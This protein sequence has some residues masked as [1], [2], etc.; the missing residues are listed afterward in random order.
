MAF[1]LR[2]RLSPA[3]LGLLKGLKDVRIWTRL[4]KFF[5]WGASSVVILVPE[6]VGRLGNNLVQLRN[7]IGLAMEVGAA[8]V[9]L[10]EDFTVSKTSVFP[11]RV[12]LDQESDGLSRPSGD[13]I[14][15]RAPVVI[16]ADWY[17]L[18]SEMPLSHTRLVEAQEMVLAAISSALGYVN[19]LE[20]SEKCVIHYRT[21]DV[22][23]SSPHKRYGPPPH[24]YYLALM[25]TWEVEE[26]TL[27]CEN[28]RETMVASLVEQLEAARVAV[29]VTNGCLEEDVFHILSCTH[30]ASSQGTFSVAL[31]S[32]NPFLR[33]FGYFETSHG[34][35]YWYPLSASCSNWVVRDNS[36]YF[37]EQ[38]Q[39]AN[40]TGSKHQTDLVETYPI[41]QLS[42]T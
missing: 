33:H 19:R 29:S 41:T 31:G 5:P 15:L 16:E 3:I 9:W 8:S 37:S 34:H 27:V 6:F 14:K 24:S 23:G 22:F 26:V 13:P 25:N 36:G 17:R 21:G 40:W 39:K 20:R 2:S 10:A 28:P 18:P 42:I 11:M 30:L 35:E 32:L 12:S 7:S 1:L 38:I 4:G